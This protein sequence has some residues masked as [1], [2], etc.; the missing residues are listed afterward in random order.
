MA[1]SG[2][3]STSAAG[4]LTDGNGRVAGEITIRAVRPDDRERIVR[5]FHALDRRSV[6]LRFFS[7]RKEL[8]AEELRQVTECDGVS[9][10][11]LVATMGSGNEETIIALADYARTG[12]ATA[13]IAFAVEE[14][15]QGRGIG[16]R[17]LQDLAKM[18]RRNGILQFEADVLAENTRML[19]VFRHSGLRMRTSQ[20]EGVVHATLFLTNAA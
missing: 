5:A 18:A 7:Y 14:D 3:F 13:H 2:P 11:V 17:L 16:S 20:S 8:S 9:R 10:G 1:D 19:N 15:F 6:Y 12:T 4:E